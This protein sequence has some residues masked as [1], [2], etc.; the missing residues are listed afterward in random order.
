MEDRQA[1][2]TLIELLIILMVLGIL[3]GITAYRFSDLLNY[4]QNLLAKVELDQVQK[5]M[6][7]YMVSQEIAT[8]PTAEC[9]SDFG[10]AEP[11]L[12]PDYLKKRTPGG[13]RSYSWDA[14]GNITPCATTQPVGGQ[15][16]GTPT[17]TSALA[18]PTPTPTSP[19]ATPTIT[20]TPSPTLPSGLASLR[21]TSMCSPDPASY[22]VWRVRNPNAV[23]VPFTWE[24]VGAGQT[25]VGLALAN[26]DVY[27]QTITV[28]GSNTVRILVDGVQHDVKA[29]TTA[30]CPQPT[31]TP[32]LTATPSPTA[33][34]TPAPSPTPTRTLTPTSTFTPTRTP[35]P[36]PTYGAPKKALIPRVYCVQNNGDGTYTAFF[37]YESL[38]DAPVYL[39]IG[40]QNKLTPGD[41]DQGQPTI[42]YP[43][44][45]AL[46]FKVSFDRWSSVVWHLNRRQAQASRFSRSCSGV[47]IIPKPLPIEPP[48]PPEIM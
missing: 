47:P 2:L 40:P 15:T 41:E 21:L 11:Q 6:W 48:R 37:G 44:T 4:A 43:G 16:A 19:P 25:G 35:T 46:V 30:H 13:G 22:R 45:H 26:S 34:F 42:F 38:N 32:T 17:P 31:A 14:A 23:D 9:V 10:L 36:T 12:W 39:P 20:P 3:L 7:A 8:V 1:G 27:F 29:S 5:G 18:T 28:P 24:V 33:T